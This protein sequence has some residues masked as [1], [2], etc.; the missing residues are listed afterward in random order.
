MQ[1]LFVFVFFLFTFTRSSKIENESDMLSS[2]DLIAFSYS[3]Q[4]SQRWDCPRISDRAE[5]A[6]EVRIWRMVI[7]DAR[8]EETTAASTSRA[9]RMAEQ[10]KWTKGDMLN[11]DSITAKGDL[12]MQN[13]ILLGMRKPNFDGNAALFKLLYSMSKQVN[14]DA[15]PV[16]LPQ[17]EQSKDKIMNWMARNQ[18]SLPILS[19]APKITDSFDSHCLHVPQAASYHPRVFRHAHFTTGDLVAWMAIAAESREKSHADAFKFFKVMVQSFLPGFDINLKAVP[20]KHAGEPTKTIYLHCSFQYVPAG[21]D[22]AFY[23]DGNRGNFL[24]LQEDSVVLN[25]PKGIVDG[26]QHAAL[27]LFSDANADASRLVMRQTKTDITMRKAFCGELEKTFA[28]R[29]SQN[30]TNAKV[31]A[32][33]VST[34]RSFA[35]QLEWVSFLEAQRKLLASRPKLLTELLPEK[36]AKLVIE[37]F[38]DDTYPIIVSTHNWTLKCKPKIAVDSARLYVMANSE[39]LK[40]LDHYLGNVKEDKRRL[41]ELIN[42]QLLA[43]LE[44]SSSHDGRYVAF[45]HLHEALADHGERT[46]S[47]TKWIIQGK[48][49]EGG[50]PKSVTVDGENLCGGILSRDGQTLFSHNI[51]RDSNVTR[52]YKFKEEPAKN[53]IK[54][55]K[56]E[57]SGF[58][59]AASGKSNRVAVVIGKQALEVHDIGKDA[60]KLVCQINASVGHICA[61]N[62]DGSEVAFSNHDG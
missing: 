47:S 17:L 56:F 20:K 48:R 34:I 57:I 16:V 27:V 39:G 38:N 33:G 14:Q 35:V 54:C 30:T 42:P 62:E 13:S 9:L 6:E 52:V 53:S 43:C 12:F 23:F 31:Q 58:V 18:A 46:K 3:Q 41:I 49:F 55:V 26:Q 51:K 24:S 37:Y 19:M 22:L 44:F 60:S 4:V 8:I 2:V 15:L 10:Y 32:V 5:K 59:R 28:L 25:R 11:N 21:A 29:V 50:R 7:P 1:L 61:L 45:S 40:G 36:L